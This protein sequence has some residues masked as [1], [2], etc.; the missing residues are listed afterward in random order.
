MEIIIIISTYHHFLLPKNEKW[1]FVAGDY[2]IE[3]FAET[4]NKSQKKIFE[5]KVTLTNEQSNDL[6]QGKA[7]YYDWAPN[8]EQYVSHADNGQ[9]KRGEVK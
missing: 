8:A 3:I 5:Q 4:V 7:I 1:D 9:Q 6:R 2:R